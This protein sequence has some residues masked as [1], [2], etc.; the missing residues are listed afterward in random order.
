MGG[1][2]SIATERPPL[3]TIPWDV[4]NG[5]L[6]PCGSSEDGKQ[7]RRGIYLGGTAE[8]LI[9]LNVECEKTRSKDTSTAN[10]LVIY[11][12][13]RMDLPSSEMKKT[14]GEAVLGVKSGIQWV[15]D[16]QSEMV[17]RRLCMRLE[18]RE[19]SW[20]Q[21]YIYESPLRKVSKAMRLRSPRDWAQRKGHEL[22]PQTPTF[23]G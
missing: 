5:G 20:L 13:T 23:R 3:A 1:G 4:I 21:T 17:K 16:I 12:A 11:A 14:V 15:L 9:R 10:W 8:W 18:F 7:V 2:T 19:R 22:S 6:G